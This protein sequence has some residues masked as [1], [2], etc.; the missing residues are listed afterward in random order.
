MIEI[1]LDGLDHLIARPQQVFVD[2]GPEGLTSLQ[3]IDAEGLSQIV[4]L[5]DPLMLPPPSAVGESSGTSNNR[6][7]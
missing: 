2:F 1:A 6:T 3:V 4:K 7:Q 5:R